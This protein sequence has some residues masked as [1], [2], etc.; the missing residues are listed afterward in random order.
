MTLAKARLL[1]EPKVLFLGLLLKG[2]RISEVKN[3]F[4][5]HDDDRSHRTVPR[6]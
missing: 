6:A 5:M 4:S 2:G 1:R 3:D